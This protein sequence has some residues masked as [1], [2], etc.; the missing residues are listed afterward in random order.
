MAE[1]LAHSPPLPLVIDYI[2]KARDITAKDEETILLALQYRDRV[3]N[4]RLLIPTTNL[5]KLLPLIE[6]EFPILEYLFIEPLTEDGK[7]M[8]LPR[9]FRAPDL[10]HLILINFALPLGSPLLVTAVGLVTLSLRHIPQ[11]IYFRPGELLRRLSFLPQLETLGITF[12]TP[13]LKLDV[14]SQLLNAPVMTHVTLPNLRWFGFKG[15]SAYL[16]A[17]LPWIT[18]PLLEKLQI[19]FFNQLTFSLPHLAPFIST[20]VN[21]RFSSSKLGFYDKGLI[22]WVY[23]HKGAKVYAWYTRIPCKHLDW[24]VSCA[25]Q[26]LNALH[27]ASLSAIV[28]LTLEYERASVSPECHDLVDRNHLHELLRSFANIKTLHVSY[29]LVRELVH[30]LQTED[31]ELPML[32][33]LKE[34]TYSGNEDASDALMPFMDIRKN[35]GCPVTLAH[36][37]MPGSWRWS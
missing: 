24:Q 15:V 4:I 30:S 32:P 20:N 29:T 34:I 33:E 14:E 10:R 17:L 26:I 3:R 18:T 19:I 21:L 7:C 36:Q 11:S 13:V 8:M 25:V 35:A 1:M 31:G 16:E 12:G 27:P 2:D 28:D 6:E 37:E 22:L 23:P 9:S 5:R